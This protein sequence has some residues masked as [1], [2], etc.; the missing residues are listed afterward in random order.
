[1][2]HDL[3]HDRAAPIPEIPHRAS[4]SEPFRDFVANREEERRRRLI[5]AA[6]L[7]EALAGVSC[8]QLAHRTGWSAETV[9]RYLQ[10]KAAPPATLLMVLAEEMGV[11]PE[12]L[13]L[14][15]GPVYLE[16]NL[17]EPRP[18]PSRQIV[19]A[20]YYLIAQQEHDRQPE[21]SHNGHG[22]RMRPSSMKR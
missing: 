10:G 15:R 8:A 21:I 11:N 12:Y 19:D 9:R 4:G 13:L 2:P 7:R 1:M 22:S 5:L 17:T 16:A 3:G 20:L 14:G 6:R 18:V